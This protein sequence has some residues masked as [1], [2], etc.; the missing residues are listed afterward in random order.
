MIAD[1]HPSI[2]GLHGKSGRWVYRQNGNVTVVSDSPKPSE[3]PATAGQQETRDRFSLATDYA[4][5]VIADP[6][7]RAHYEPVAQAKGKGVYRVAMNDALSKPKVL[8][9]DLSAYN[10][11]DGDTITVRALDDYGVTGVRVSIS[12]GEWLEEGNAV[13]TVDSLGRWVYTV[14]GNAPA[15]DLTIEAAA[16]DRPGNKGTK[17]VTVQ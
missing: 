12:N 17:S 6:V 7:S 8:E 2:R 10:R 5:A 13:K 9:I 14:T 4:K 3:K 1:L 16:T 11:M 15:G